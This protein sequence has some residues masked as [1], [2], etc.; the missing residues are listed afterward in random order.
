MAGGGSQGL[1]GDGVSGSSSDPSLAHVSDPPER[2]QRGLT[3]GE[4]CRIAVS[5]GRYGPHHGCFLPQLRCVVVSPDQSR[6]PL[7]VNGGWQ[8]LVV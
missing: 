6:C 4:F 1:Q 7:L 8:E 3:S 5:E 2:I